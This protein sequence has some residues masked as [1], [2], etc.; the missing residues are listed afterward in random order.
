MD[1][2]YV[3]S[4]SVDQ[5]GYDEDQREAHVIFKNGRHYV[6]SDVSEE[7]WDRLKDAQSKGTFI[8]QE[9]KA[10]AYPYRQV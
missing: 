5:I 1:F 10:K 2:I 6:Y 3:D 4:T 9:F 7:I 8:N